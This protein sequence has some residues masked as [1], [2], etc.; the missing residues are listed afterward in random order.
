MICL[1]EKIEKD[2]WLKIM[3]YSQTEINPLKSTLN[4]AHKMFEILY[5]TLFFYT[6]FYHSQNPYWV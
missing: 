2:I 6:F 5:D 1:K 3:N 4:T